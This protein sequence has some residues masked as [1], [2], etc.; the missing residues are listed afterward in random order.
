MSPE[1][2]L[3]AYTEPYNVEVDEEVRLKYFVAD[4]SW[5]WWRGPSSSDE[6]SVANANIEVKVYSRRDNGELGREVLVLSTTADKFGQGELILDIPKE[7]AGEYRNF[8]AKIEEV[9]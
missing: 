3:W 7:I 9:I 5:W 8:I 1:L 6:S 4:G 2:Y